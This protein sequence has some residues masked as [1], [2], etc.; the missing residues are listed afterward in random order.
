MASPFT[1][2]NG[3][4]NEMTSESSFAFN[5]CEVSTKK[6]NTN[7]H[8]SKSASEG[9]DERFKTSKA[10]QAEKSIVNR[11]WRAF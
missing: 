5:G 10:S 9:K 1:G 11:E 7:I 2:G 8:V 4:M 6:N 3:F